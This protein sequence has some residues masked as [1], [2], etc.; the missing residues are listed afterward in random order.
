MNLDGIL[1][2]LVES[3]LSGKKIDAC[4]VEE[5]CRQLDVVKKRLHECAHVTWGN[6][7]TWMREDQNKLDELMAHGGCDTCE[8]CLPG[9]I[10]PVAA[11]GNEKHVWVECCGSCGVFESDLMAAHFIGRMLNLPVKMAFHTN[12]YSARPYVDGITIDEGEVVM[13]RIRKVH[14]R[15]LLKRPLLKDAG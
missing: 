11:N 12:G 6:R 3:K 15:Q 13:G 2:A 4:L 14:A 10:F 5:Y 9:I 1:V 8:S 7:S